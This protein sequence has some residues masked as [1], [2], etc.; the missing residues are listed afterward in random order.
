ME[1]SGFGGDLATQ[2]VQPLGAEDGQF[3]G[4][5][6]SQLDPTAHGADYG[7]LDFT[8]QEP[9]TA[10]DAYQFTSFS[11]VGGRWACSSAL[12]QRCMPLRVA[13]QHSVG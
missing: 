10:G 4:A 1:R 3:T 8:Q 9:S 12:W 7:F 5:D 13:R 6:G 11:Q 2:S